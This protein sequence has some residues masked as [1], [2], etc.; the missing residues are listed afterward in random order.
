MM[1]RKRRTGAVIVFT[2]LII[3][4]VN[5]AWW[6]FY[7][8]TS[9]SFESQLSHRL[10]SIAHLG[11]SMIKPELVSS[12]KEGYLTAYDPILGILEDIKD[13]DSLSEVFLIDD[14]YI[15]LA[16]TSLEADTVYYLSVLN[17]PY[18]DSL[19]LNN[20][21]PDPL[22]ASNLPIV[23]PGY[24]VGDI[25][26]KSAYAPVRDSAGVII[27]ALGVEADVD[28][29]D[30]LFDLKRNLYLSTGISLAAG[31]L[32][33]LFFVLFQRKI[34]AAEKSLFLSQSQANLG[35]MVAV[36]SHEIKNPLMII[37]GSAER[38][39]KSGMK[40]AEFIVEET[41]RL[42]D[43]V[44]GYLDF[45]TGKKILKTGNVDIKNILADIV[46]KFT[47]RLAAGGTK[48]TLDADSE[49][50]SI[51]KADAAAIRQVI[52]NLILNAAEACRETEKAEVKIKANKTAGRAIIRIIDNGPGIS[53]KEMKS[54]FEPFY[55]TK[56]TG[57]GLGLY[58]SKQLLEQMAGAI[59]VE[60]R[61]GGPTVFIITL[62]MADK[63]I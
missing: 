28:Y 57:S 46:E 23:T 34:N 12:L 31:V 9:R 1:Q 6:L 52:I 17:G 45:A 14:N 44:T 8:R 21:R 33:G 16:T 38:L 27:A 55:T 58:H 54:I 37:R 41:D 11:A 40:E 25:V 62:P 49:N 59:A 19:F 7:N 61:D 32:F 29:T 2:V 13:A 50:S 56:T 22:A 39:I 51:V 24:R 15:Y 3:I 53:R 48:L 63:G 18:I 43:I 60:S 42:N 47:A 20:W 35:R 36:V 10:A 4:L 5:M 26:L 30:V